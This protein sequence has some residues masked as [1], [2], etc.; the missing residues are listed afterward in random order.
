M[1]RRS[2]S[3]AALVALAVLASPAA[4]TTETAT[5]GAVTATLSYEHAN[6]SAEWRD[7]LLTITRDGQTALSADP[8]FGDCESPYCAPGGFADRGSVFADD[9]DGDGEPEVMVDLFTGGAHCCLVTRFY[10]W[11]GAAYV[12]AERN[13][14]DPG[15]RIADL[16]GDGIKEIVTSDW[17]FGYSFT[18]FAFSLMPVRIYHLRAGSWQLVTTQFP[19]EIR[20]DAKANWRLFQKAG[21]QDEPRGAVAAWA[22]DQLMLGHGTHARHTLDRLARAGRLHGSFPTSQRKFVRNLLRFLAKRGY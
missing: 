20:K 12:P 16:D 2:T 10:R 3:L 18:A 8:R 1:R 22:A 14:H 11:D 6:E 7:L 9:L 5:S 19:D 17:R 13:F 4:A 21:R 15:Y